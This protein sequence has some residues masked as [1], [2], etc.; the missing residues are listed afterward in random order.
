MNLRISLPTARRIVI[1][2]ALILLFF[3]SGYWLGQRGIVFGT[4][5]KPVKVTISREL[6]KDKRQLDFSLFWEV[7]DKLASDFYGKEELNEAKL[8]F[9]AIK[10]MV[11]AAGDPYTAFLEPSEQKVTTEDLSGSFEGV[12]IQIGF[13]GTQLAIIAPLEGSPAKKAGLRAG[14]FILLIK[15]EKRNIEKGTIGIDL[16]TAVNA[17]RGPA[18]TWVTLTIAR[19]G[20][21]KP[22]EVTLTRERIDVP[23]VELK[24]VDVE[25]GKVAHLKLLRFGEATS[26]EWD[27]K[28]SEILATAGVKGIVLDL[29]NNPGGFLTGAVFIGSEFIKSGTIVVQEDAKGNKQTFSATGKGRLTRFPLVVLV[30]KGSASASE[31]VAGAVRDLG[32]AKVIGETTFGKGTIQEAQELK[33]GAGIHITTARWLTPKGTWVNGEGLKPDIEVEDN[34]ETEGDEQLGRA[35]EEVVK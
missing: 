14:D 8:V 1:F 11:Q 33:G 4:K 9:G 7:W 10:G 21:E 22:F 19:E 35:V 24:F 31:I 5:D 20:V 2:L 13:K 34:E 29:R 23:S 3:G 30:N 18:G 32:K 25:G 26:S 28:V 17:I 27:Q 6:P 12:G 16:P 15:D